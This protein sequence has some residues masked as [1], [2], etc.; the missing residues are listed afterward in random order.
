MKNPMNLVICAALVLGATACGEE[1]TEANDDTEATPAAAAAPTSSGSPAAGGSGTNFGTVTLAAGFTA[2]HI[3]EGRSGGNVDAS[4]LN[5]DCVGN[6]DSTPDHALELAAPMPGL[7]IFAASER[8]ITLVVQTPD[9]NYLCNDD[10]D[11]TNPLV[12]AESFAAGTY[13]I[14]IGNYDA[15]EGAAAY[16]LAFSTVADASPARL[17]Q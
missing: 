2:P 8:D 17:T 3:V 15:S 13:R 12:T 16:R 5:P 9:G 11:G 6:V 14:W 1:G 10:F 4:T 7:R